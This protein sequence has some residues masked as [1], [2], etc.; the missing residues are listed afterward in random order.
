MILLL[1]AGDTGKTSR[2]LKK[3]K[4]IAKRE[5]MSF[6]SFRDFKDGIPP[7]LSSFYEAP[8]L[9]GGEDGSSS[10]WEFVIKTNKSTQMN[11]AAFGATFKKCLLLSQRLHSL[12]EEDPS[13]FWDRFCLPLVRRSVQAASELM[14][15]SHTPEKGEEGIDAGRGGGVLLMPNA[16][17]SL[18]SILET[19]VR[20][21]HSLPSRVRSE[22]RRH[23][24][25]G[26]LEPIY[27]ATRKMINDYLVKSF[28]CVSVSIRPIRR[29]LSPNQDFR[30]EEERPKSVWERRLTSEGLS[31]FEE[32][33]AFFLDAL[34]LAHFGEL[35]D[36]S[37]R[38]GGGEG[39]KKGS[40]DILICDH[41]ASQT[42]RTLPLLPII[43]W[44]R[45]HSVVLVVD[46][47]GLPD[48]FSLRELCEKRRLAVNSGGKNGKEERNFQSE[49]GGEK[50]GEEK[51]ATELE[52]EKE[53]RERPDDGWPEYYVL[54]THK[55]IGNVKTC[56]VVRVGAGAPCCPLP[57][58]ISFGYDSSLFLE[59]EP[60]RGNWWNGR[61]GARG[62]QDGKEKQ[63][64]WEKQVNAHMWVGMTDYV[65]FITL[66]VAISIYLRE[67]RRN[68]VQCANLLKEGL[69]RAGLTSMLCTNS[70]AGGT[71]HQGLRV[72]TT[73][74]ILRTE[75]VHIEGKGG[76]LLQEVM[77]DVGIRAS[78]KLF[79]G[80]QFLRIGVNSYLSRFDFDVVANFLGHQLHRGVLR[81][82]AGLISQEEGAALKKRE[83]EWEYLAS[84]SMVDCL[85]SAAVFPLLEDSEVLFHQNPLLLDLLRFSSWMGI[86]C[87]FLV[88]PLGESNK[89][90][91]YEDIIGAKTSGFPTPESVAQS[92]GGENKGLFHNENFTSLLSTQRL[93]RSEVVKAIRTQP[94]VLPLHSDSFHAIVLAFVQHV[95]GLLGACVEI[96]HDCPLPPPSISSSPICHPNLAS[97]INP[98]LSAC[99]FCGPNLLPLETPQNQLLKCEGGKVVQ[100]DLDDGSAVVTAVPPFLVSKYLVSNSE[101]LD[102]VTS[103]AYYDPCWWSPSSSAPPPFPPRWRRKSPSDQKNPGCS[104]GR[105]EGKMGLYWL[106]TLTEEVEMRW[107]W[108]VEVTMREATAFCRWKNGQLGYRENEVSLMSFLQWKVLMKERREAPAGDRRCN[109]S[110]REFSSPCPVNY[111]DST[112]CSSSEKIYDVEGNVWQHC[113]S[114]LREYSQSPASTDCPPPMAVMG[115]DSV[116]VGGSW[117]TTGC[118]WSSNDGFGLLLGGIRYVKRMRYGR[119]EGEGGEHGRRPTEGLLAEI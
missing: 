106:R 41:V 100:P 31:L 46:G 28:P 95:Y 69:H 27:G 36:H 63:E 50:G 87:S 10:D 33:P 104:V 86:D 6:G 71:S 18:R 49:K 45:S 51:G 109:M 40:L 38:E 16:T 22:E 74:P 88:P 90:K 9:A 83:I 75:G 70:G 32:E 61:K 108:P 97:P 11:H 68:L 72:L 80:W 116:L 67:G 98:F 60:G 62:F 39:S 117:D 113:S 89:K 65:P 2:I 54:S 55:W 92:G 93:I 42:G 85:I 3:K 4:K 17:T 99:S 76:F 52:G 101:Y 7:S 23:V 77:D 5:G 73:C 105:Q 115:R 15:C 47:T 96:L 24:R 103:E 14:D 119:G 56:S 43:E 30:G 94:L 102:F 58:G 112:L 111:F 66:A 12:S 44:C 107:D 59:K 81:W 13:D 114:S 34:N 35:C 48:F 8:S 118:G 53:N 84:Q 37:S 21:P 57:V 1:I 82:E 91:L 29:W 64:M 79:E 110:L 25:I 78:C 19:L 20:C 26:V